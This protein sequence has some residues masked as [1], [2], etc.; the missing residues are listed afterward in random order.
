M[1]G[2]TSPCYQSQSEGDEDVG[3][4][5]TWA[6][7][8]PTKTV[9]VVGEAAATT[10]KLTYSCPSMVLGRMFVPPFSH[11]FFGVPSLLFRLGVFLSFGRFVLDLQWAGYK[12]TFCIVSSEEFTYRW[13]WIVPCLWLV[14]VSLIMLHTNR[15]TFWWV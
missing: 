9:A 6:R 13:P 5:L 7:A 8:G 11:V 14:Y 10:I 2:L 1:R 15:L 4:R 3:Y 12:V